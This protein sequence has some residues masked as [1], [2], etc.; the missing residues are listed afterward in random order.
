MHTLTPF[1]FW[2]DFGLFVMTL[3]VRL[4]KSIEV[5]CK[6]AICKQARQASWLWQLRY[7]VFR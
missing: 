7:C 1:E 6:Q 3:S 2:I 4:G 5:I